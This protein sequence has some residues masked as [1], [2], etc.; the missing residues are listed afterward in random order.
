MGFSEEDCVQRK[1][2][3]PTNAMLAQFSSKRDKSIAT[4]REENLTGLL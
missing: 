1:A 2:I 3:A 4:T